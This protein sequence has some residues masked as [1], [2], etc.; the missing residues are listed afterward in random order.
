[1]CLLESSDGIKWN[2]AFGHGVKS[3]KYRRNNIVIDFQK[4]NPEGPWFGWHGFSPFIDTNPDALPSERYKAVGKNDGGAVTGL[5][6]LVSPDGVTWKLKSE[7]PIFQC[8]GEGLGGDA[9][10]LDS[11]NVIFFDNDANQYRL[12]FRRWFFRDGLSAESNPSFSEEKRWAFYIANGIRGIMTATSRDLRKWSKPEWL[13]YG[14]AD[15]FT[16]LYTNNIQPYYRAPHLWMGFPGRYIQHAMSKAV[17]LLPEP[18]L[19]KLRKGRHGSAV[20]DALFMSS[21]NGVDFRRFDEAFIRPGLHAEGN[22]TYGDNVP[23]LGMLETNSDQPGGGRE[24]SF[25]TIDNYWRNSRIVRNTLRIDG[26]VSLRA[27]YRGGEIITK[28]FIFKGDELSLNFSVSAAGRMK[29][30]ILDEHMRLVPGFEMEN[31][32][33]ILGD[34]LDYRVHWNKSGSKVGSLAGKTIRLRVLMNDADWFSWRFI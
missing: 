24:L 18:E 13:S 29:V 33:D 20:S 7:T 14:V 17:E 3:E 16:Q 21:R 26:F 34:S 15:P 23:A 8:K 2:R 5:F 27:P 6:L 10:C 28:P 4:Q 11:Q 19:R 12:Y 1:M 9:T 25:Y 32:I 22:W 31:C 30:E